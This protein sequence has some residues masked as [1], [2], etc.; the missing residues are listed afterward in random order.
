MVDAI[1]SIRAKVALV[2]WCKRHKLPV[3]VS[4]GAGGKTDPTQIRIDDLSRTTMDPLASRLRA[5]L[6]RHHGFSREA[7]KRFGI[8][9]VY[10]TEQLRYPDGAGGVCQSRAQSDG[11]LKMDCASGFGATTVVTASVGLA[12][13][14]RVLQRL[15][16][17]KG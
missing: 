1:D 12:A 14:S 17:S 10:S 15:A 4:G 8:D 9:C 11:Q 16:G 13:V 3:I 7:G 5:D 6:R 2:A